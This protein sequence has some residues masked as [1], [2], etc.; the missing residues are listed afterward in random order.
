MVLSR[1]FAAAR[2]NSRL[3]MQFSIPEGWLTGTAAVSQHLYSLLVALQTLA[4]VIARKMGWVR[5]SFPNLLRL[6]FGSVLLALH[7]QVIRKKKSLN[8]TVTSI[9]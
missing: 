9:P 5:R 8:T 6:V 3:L 1:A 4:A 2:M 7:L